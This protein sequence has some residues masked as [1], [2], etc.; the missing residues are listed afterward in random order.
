MN[1]L[2]QTSPLR[3][4]SLFVDRVHFNDSGYD[5][6]ARLIVDPVL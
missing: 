3:E 1:R 6:A 2:L 5:E 4:S